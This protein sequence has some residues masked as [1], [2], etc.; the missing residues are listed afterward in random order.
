[1]KPIYIIVYLPLVFAACTASK[2]PP[3]KKMGTIT[4]IT[5]LSGSCGNRPK[6]LPMACQSK[7]FSIPIIISDSSNNIIKNIMSNKNGVF[8]IK[9]EPGHYL[10]STKS[11]P[12]YPK[13]TEQVTVT[14]GIN[15]KIIISV[16]INTR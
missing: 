15:K 13:Q 12:I 14:E 7:P 5:E 11:S 16:P 4:G 3:E 9:L 1:M 6:H 2:M 10:I 8:K